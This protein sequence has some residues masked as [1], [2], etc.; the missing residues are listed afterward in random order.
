MF[1]PLEGVAVM[2]KW[3]IKL[4]PS[5]LLKKTTT[6]LVRPVHIEVKDKRC[7]QQNLDG[8]EK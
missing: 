3:W 6:P 7:E 8:S 4:P 1:T 2:G 5:T